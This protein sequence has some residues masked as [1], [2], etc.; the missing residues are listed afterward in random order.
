[1]NYGRRIASGVFIIVAWLVVYSTSVADV[2]YE[3][4][5]FG[6]KATGDVKVTSG[7]VNLGKE[8]YR[9]K[10]TTEFCTLTGSQGCTASDFDP[11]KCGKYQQYS[12]KYDWTNVDQV[13]VIMAAIGNGNVPVVVGTLVETAVNTPAQAGKTVVTA[14]AKGGTAAAKGVATAGKAVGSAAHH[15]A[16]K[17]HIGK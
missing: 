14:V 6:D 9:V 1:M 8:W 11:Q 17:I 5:V 15:A 2:N 3:Y 16:C 13:K 4:C 7:T 12:F 10:A